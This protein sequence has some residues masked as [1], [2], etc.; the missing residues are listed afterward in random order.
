M[1]SQFITV[2]RQF[3]L[4]PLVNLISVYN[5]C[6]E[7]HGWQL[8]PSEN[9]RSRML[10]LLLL[11]SFLVAGF[12]S[13]PVLLLLIPWWTP[14]LT[15]QVSACSTF[16]MMCHVPSMAVF[17]GNLLSVV[18]VLFPYIFVNFCLQYYLLILLSLLLYI[19][20]IQL[21]KLKYV[22]DRGILRKLE[23]VLG[24]QKSAQARAR[25]I[26]LNC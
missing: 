8:H 17:V 6:T 20:R 11:L 19:S 18:L 13:S 22:M 3:S 10:L 9:L 4:S 24:Q 2:C 21:N 7:D 1:R 23:V 26:L 5:T 14:P 15:L 16:L 12:L 25:S